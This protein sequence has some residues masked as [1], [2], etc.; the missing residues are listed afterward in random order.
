MSVG[1]FISGLMNDQI[2]AFIMSMLI[3]FVLFLVGEPSVTMA[4]DGWADGFGTFL[5]NG[6]GLPPHFN[7]M[8]QGVVKLTDLIYF[9]GSRA[10]S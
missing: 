4:I 10:S 7:S 5:A 9:V 6:L 1:I 2:S 3:C 8:R